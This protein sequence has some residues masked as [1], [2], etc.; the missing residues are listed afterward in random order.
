MD[1]SKR[2]LYSSKAE[3]D[4]SEEREKKRRRAELFV[5]ARQMVKIEKK[6]VERSRAN[7]GRGRPV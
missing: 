3:T 4:H 1:M 2:K 7:L 6:Y 5:R